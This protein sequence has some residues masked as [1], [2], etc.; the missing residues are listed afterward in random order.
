MARPGSLDWKSITDSA[1]RDRERKPKLRSQ[2]GIRAQKRR[3]IAAWGGEIVRSDKT[4]ECLLIKNCANTLRKLK[5]FL[6]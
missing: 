4:N 1:V 5:A 6:F 2:S 3:I